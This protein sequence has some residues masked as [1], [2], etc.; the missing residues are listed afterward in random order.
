MDRLLRDLPYF[1]EVA[2]QKSFTLAADALDVPLST[3]SRRIA[4]ME[5]DLGVQLLYRTTR[6]VELTESGKTFFEECD[7]ILTEME[8][9]RERMLRDLQQPSGR[10]RLSLTADFYHVYMGDALS[11]FAALYPDI[12]MHVH[13]STRWVDL[14]SEPF[15]LEIRGGH[16]PDSD[17]KSRKLYT[18][19]PALYASPALLEFYKTPENPDDLK[20]IPF[21][22]QMTPGTYA[23]NLRK[24]NQEKTISLR[25]KYIVNNVSICLEFVLKGLGAGALVTPLTK[26]YEQKDQLIRLLPGWR[27][28]GVD[29]NVVMPTGDLPYRTRLFVNYL[30]EYFA[31]LPK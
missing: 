11:S 1:M 26:K 23:L 7:H 28:P 27:L 5:N 21:I 29:I 10:V 20:N 15:D 6:S 13:F 24:G 25:P 19:Y 17:L 8:N 9:A 12:E 16:L 3:L 31:S 18:V 14:N 2:R 22:F 4:A 30:V